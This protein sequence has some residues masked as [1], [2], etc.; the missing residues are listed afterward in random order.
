M[1]SR[2][3]RP[4]PQML[5][6]SLGVFRH[7]LEPTIMSPAQQHSI[8]MSSDGS[9]ERPCL[10]RHRAAAQRAALLLLLLLAAL[11]GLA[12]LDSFVKGGAARTSCPPDYECYDSA[13]SGQFASALVSLCDPRLSGAKCLGTTSRKVALIGTPDNPAVISHKRLPVGRSMT[14]KLLHVILEDNDC[15]ADYN[16]G[17]LLFVD[18][19]TVVANHV[20]LRRG[21]ARSGGAV[22]VEADGRFAC[23]DC[24]FEH[25]TAQFYGGALVN[26]GA[27]KLVRPTFTAN[28][29]GAAGH[30]LMFTCI[31]NSGKPC[32]TIPFVSLRRISECTAYGKDCNCDVNSPLCSGCTCHKGKGGTFCP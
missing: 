23:T 3:E 8:F 17:G 13:H 16:N 7:E 19:G 5:T 30:W 26:F 28:T 2:S 6:D 31:C 32:G 10:A 18:G 22:D 27:L 20:T 25:N 21:V 1:F 24:R 14:V 12:Q 11:V 29:A 15:T 4:A 9:S